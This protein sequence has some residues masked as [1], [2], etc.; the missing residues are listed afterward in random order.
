VQIS[1]LLRDLADCGVVDQ[2]IMY[3][4]VSFEAIA[5]LFHE[6][7]SGYVVFV[8]QNEPWWECSAC[9]LRGSTSTC[10]R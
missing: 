5:E 8:G 10:P 3:S 7:A 6:S 4:S 9:D 2:T 1:W